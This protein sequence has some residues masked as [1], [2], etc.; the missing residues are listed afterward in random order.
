M[1]QIQGK[2]NLHSLYW[3]RP[4]ALKSA[5][6]SQGSDIEACKLKVTQ[7]FSFF[8]LTRGKYKELTSI[9]P[10]LS[11]ERWQKHSW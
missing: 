3:Y 2:E 8:L 5:D 11:T 10:S 1:T 6:H 4:A 7:C 9:I